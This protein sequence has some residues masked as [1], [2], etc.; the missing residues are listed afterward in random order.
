MRINLFAKIV[1]DA[2]EDGR[3]VFKRNLGFKIATTRIEVL[4]HPPRR[5]GP[6]AADAAEAP[7]VDS[8]RGPPP[9]RGVRPGSGRL[10]PSEAAT[11]KS[12]PTGEYGSSEEL[13][14]VR[15]RGC[16]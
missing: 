3:S 2:A 15:N 5:A 1:A 11:G 10:G 14:H 16:N 13:L 9:A 12:R 6:A 7:A 4:A 8:R